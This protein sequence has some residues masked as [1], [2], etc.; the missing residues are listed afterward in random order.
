MIGASPIADKPVPEPRQVAATFTLY[1][2]ERLTK[3]MIWKAFELAVSHEPEA[4]HRVGPEG[5]LLLWN[6]PEDLPAAR[7]ENIMYLNAEHVCATV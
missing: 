6:L 7:H 4:D 3:F 5:L 1:G 2:G